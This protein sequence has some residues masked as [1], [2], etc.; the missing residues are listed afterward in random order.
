MS[1]NPQNERADISAQ[2]IGASAQAADPLTDFIPLLDAA[3][4]HV[5][6]NNAFRILGVSAYATERDVRRQLPA[7]S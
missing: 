4:P 6:R 5:Y 2:G 7:R 3:N 1:D